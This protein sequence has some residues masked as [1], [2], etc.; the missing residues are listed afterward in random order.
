MHPFIH[1]FIH[2]FI[3]QSIVILIAFVKRAPSHRNRL[4]N[5]SP[6]ED[7]VVTCK[8][9]SAWRPRRNEFW[10]GFWRKG[11]WTTA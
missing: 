7:A 6:G 4:T 10:V 3:Y 2:L 9:P 8:Y 5:Q 1:S 11:I